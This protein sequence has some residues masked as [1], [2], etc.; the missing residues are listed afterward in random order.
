MLACSSTKAT[1]Q[2]CSA[3]ETPAG[4][5]ATQ[6]AVH[7]RADVLPIFTQS[8]AF[9]SCH[10]N[11]GGLAGGVF[12]GTKDNTDPAEVRNNVVGVPA[13]ELASMPLVSPGDPKNSFLMRKL[14]GDQCLL[15]AQC[16]DKSCGETMP[17]T[18]DQ[19]PVADRDKI[20]RWIAQ[21]AKDD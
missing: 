14:D 12:L 19:L 2:E 10:G 3:Y 4:F 15:D 18:G 11:R 13:P 1:P 7:F 20:R 9:T 21:G 6:P 8:C 17:R 16:K 5:D